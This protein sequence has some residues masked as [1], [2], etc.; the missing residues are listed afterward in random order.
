MDD[1]KK[2]K[3]YKYFRNINAMMAVGTDDFK[4]SLFKATDP[5]DFNK[6]HIGEIIKILREHLLEGKYSDHN[7]LNELVDFHKKT[8][9][10]FV[11]N[12]KSL[13]VIH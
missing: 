3:T 2:S 1:L 7:Y 9:S 5:E 10:E 13:H 4:M 8:A 11:K 12:L 6:K